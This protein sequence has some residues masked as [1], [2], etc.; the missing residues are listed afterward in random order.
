MK[1]ITLLFS[2]FAFL[3]LSC[4]NDDD[5]QQIDDMS[6]I[7]LQK[8]VTQSEEG[9]YETVFKY[10]GKKLVEAKSALQNKQFNYTGDK[11]TKISWYTNPNADNQLMQY[12]D[13]EYLPDGKLKSFKKYI[14]API[15]VEF[16]YV[17]EDTVNFVA[18]AERGAYSFYGY[19]KVKNNEILQYVYLDGGR[20][21]PSVNY[22]Y[23]EKNHPLRNV[24]GY[25]NLFLFHYFCSSFHVDGFTT[26]IGS[27]KNC[28]SNSLIDNPSVIEITNMYEYNNDGFPKTIRQNDDSTSD[29]LFY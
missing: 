15:N 2:F 13:F 8:I 3:F 6:N 22:Q 21:R 18:T 10:D 16:T 29:S 24:T 7:L 5:S 12:V 26:N 11:I 27:S 28:I 4:A 20:P 17:G 9:N 25:G 1:K 19:F 14:N 23:D